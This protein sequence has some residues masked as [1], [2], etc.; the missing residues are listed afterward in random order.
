MNYFDPW[1][2]DECSSTLRMCHYNPG[3]GNYSEEQMLDK[4]NQILV[5]PPQM[6]FGFLKLMNTFEEDGYQIEL[7]GKYYPIKCKKN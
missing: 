6:D 4:R 3:M 1:F 5:V 7:K 2:K